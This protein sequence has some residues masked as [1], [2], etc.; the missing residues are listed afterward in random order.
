MNAMDFPQFNPPVHKRNPRHTGSGRRIVGMAD[1][2]TWKIVLPGL[3]A[4]EV[5]TVRAAGYQ[6]SEEAWSTEA[7]WG[8]GPPGEFKPT[9]WLARARAGSA[10]DAQALIVEALGRTPEGIQALGRM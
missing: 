9:L 2:G 4:E 1:W 10:E 6:V 3:S 8:N 5:E 7:A